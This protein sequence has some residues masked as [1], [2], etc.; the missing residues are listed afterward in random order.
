MD[1]RDRRDV[2]SAS[3]RV[4][5]VR[6]VGALGL[7]GKEEAMIGP[8]HPEVGRELQRTRREEIARALRDAP[9]SAGGRSSHDGAKDERVTRS[10]SRSARASVCR[11]PSMEAFRLFTEH[12]DR[13]WPVEVLSR[14]ARR[15]VRRRCQG[16]TGRLRA[17]RR[18]SPLRG[19]VRRVS[20]G[21]GLTLPPSSLRP[22][23]CSPGSRTTGPT[24]DR[25]RDPFE[26]DG[27]GTIVRLEHRGWEELGARAA[28]AREGHDGG[29]RLPL[30]R[31]VAAAAA[32]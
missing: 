13:W 15:A 2:G 28:E 14:A 3:R 31:F 25:G 4:Q 9:A 1:A 12:I 10:P 22:G 26:Q 23:S 6:G 16:G 17:S 5:G 32:G 27:D 24:S 7:D 11:S 18:W 30:E 29:W 19:H 8:V 20:K 21:S